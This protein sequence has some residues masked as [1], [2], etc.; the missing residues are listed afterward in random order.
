MKKSGKNNSKNKRPFK[1]KCLVQENEKYESTNREIIEKPKDEQENEDENESEENENE[2]EENEIN[3]KINISGDES[4]ESEEEKAME[5]KDFNLKLFML[6]YGQCDPKMCTGMRLMKY[7]LLKE[8]KINS[9][10]QGILLTPT[11]KKMVSK[12]D[13]EIIKTKGICVIDC[14]WAKFNSLHINLNKIETR[15][16]PYLVA[17]NPVNYG[18]AHKLTC[19]EAIGASLFLAGFYQETDYLMS[20]FKWGSSF[21]EVNSELFGMYKSCNN[22]AEM[23]AIEEKYI[24]DEV[25]S[26]RVKKLQTDDI[27]FTDEEN[28]EEEEE[29]DYQSLFSKVDLDDMS[30]QLSRK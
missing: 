20:H 24:S 27:V 8:M 15:L 18:K 11:G 28:D 2:S 23:K 7:G 17:V 21:L 9:K 16:M 6:N 14:S 5:K 25:E 30:D 3:G 4:S 22:G 13:H 26:K 12:E 10:F 19:V 1:N 29:V